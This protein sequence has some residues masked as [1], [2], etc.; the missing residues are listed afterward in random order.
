MY[1]IISPDAAP[2]NPQ[3]MLSSAPDIQISPLDMSCTGRSV[4]HGCPRWRG[5]KDF[6]SD[7]CERLKAYQFGQP[8]EHLPFS[9]V[10]NRRKR[11]R[12]RA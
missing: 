3:V 7:T 2:K 5:D 11:G 10:S 8:Y 1:N 9:R 6:C 12:A 4:C